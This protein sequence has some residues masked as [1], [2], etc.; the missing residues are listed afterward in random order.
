[1]GNVIIFVD[2]FNLYM[3]Q[4]FVLLVLLVLIPKAYAQP[5]ATVKKSP[6]SFEYLDSVNDT[7]KGET[8][9]G[10]EVISTEGKLISNETIKGKVTLFIFWFEGCSGCKQEI[11]ELN[12][13]YNSLKNNQDVEFMALTYDEKES[14]PDFLKKFNMHYPV[15]TTGNIAEFKKLCYHMASPSIVLLDKKGQVNYLAL[16]SVSFDEVE[17][18]VSIKTL[19]GMIRGLI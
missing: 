18:H 6:W 11:N 13:L 15:A 10:F 7:H 19:L 4:L 2:T 3:R 16:R 9:P 14:L 1:M 5:N 12:A 17:H 8:Y